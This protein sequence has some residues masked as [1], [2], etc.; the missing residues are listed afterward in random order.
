V[1][2]TDICLSAAEEPD[3]SLDSVLEVYC[4][5]Q[6]LCTGWGCLLHHPYNLSLTIH[7]F[8][9]PKEFTYEAI[10]AYNEICTQAQEWIEDFGPDKYLNFIRGHGFAAT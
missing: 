8:N 9:T 4:V 2:R 5:A 7:N 3:D 10:T 1:Y 6:V